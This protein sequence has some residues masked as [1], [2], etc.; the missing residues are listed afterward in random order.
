MIK[1]K[2][3]LT[4]EWITHKGKTLWFPAHTKATFD[5]IGSRSYIALYPKQMESMF[6]K[7]PI[8]SFHVT[9]PNHIKQVGKIIG[10]K[11]SISTFTRANNDSPLAKGRGIQTGTG[12]VIFY[13]QGTLLATRYMDFDTIPDKTGRRWVDGHFITGDRQMFR[14]AYD[15]SGIP[16]K[17]EKLFDKIYDIKKKYEKEW[18]ED[19]DKM[20]YNEYQKMVEK[21]TG[22]FINQFIKEFFNWQ[23]KWLKANKELIKKNLRT[24]S[25]KP[26]A[27]WNEILIY[28]TRV[29]DAFVLSRITKDGM[30]MQQ[31][32]DNK[33]GPW[34]KELYSYVPK[35]KVTIGT[36][37][38]FRKWYGARQ[39]IIDQI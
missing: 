21:K 15:S 13:V 27:W 39:G 28:N 16:K 34:Q 18:M 10:K 35:S 23:N 36:P 14:K 37:A 4:E 2:D 24:P 29:I 22:P 31:Y 3:L 11:K 38:K 8:S 19:D 33:P 6:G 17:R 7:Q 25:N 20:P 32:G 30:W 9:S 26:S 5:M 1:L 12:G